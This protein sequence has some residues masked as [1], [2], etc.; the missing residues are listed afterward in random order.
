[1]P[2]PLVSPSAPGDLQRSV[3][4]YTGVLGMALLNRER[5]VVRMGV[6]ATGQPLVV[7]REQRGIA[8]APR[9]GRFGLFHFAVLLPDR[10]SNR[11]RASHTGRKKLIVNDIVVNDS[12]GCRW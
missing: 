11:K 4:Y 2:L 6:G 10:P 7:L 3:D 9:A 12:S 8:P 1:M 5:D